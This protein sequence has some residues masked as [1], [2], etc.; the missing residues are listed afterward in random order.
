MMQCPPHLCRQ[1]YLCTAFFKNN[2]ED[3]AVF[4]ITQL[5]EDREVETKPLM[6]GSLT[7]KENKTL[8]CL[9]LTGIGSWSR[10]KS[11]SP[12]ASAGSERDLQCVKKELRSALHLAGLPTPDP[13]SF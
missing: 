10:P 12:S 4:G 1:R 11:S 3:Y 2:P 8:E 13:S 9:M 6:V 5:L 7:A